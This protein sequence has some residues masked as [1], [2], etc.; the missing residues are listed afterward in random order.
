MKKSTILLAVVL[1]SAAVIGQITKKVCFLG[2]SYTY[3]NNLPALIDSVANHD[4]RDLIK[5]QNTPGGH[6]LDAHSTN[7]TS[8]AKISSNTWDYV[9]LQ[10]QSQLPSFPY[11]QTSVSV[12]PKAEILCDSIRSA[13]ECAVPLFYN[14]WGREIGDSQWDS[15]NTF[16]KM[17]NRLFIAYDYM[18]E[19][20]SGKLSPVGIGFRQVYDDAS[21]IVTNGDLYSSDGS[22]PSM[23]GSYLAACIFYNVIFETTSVGNT[24]LPS[25]VSSGQAA[26][27]QNVANHVVFD[28][29]SVSI[30]YT[31]PI[32]NFL[33]TINGSNVDFSNTSLHAYDYSWDFGDGGSSLL[34][35]PSHAY[36]QYGNYT[37]VLT[38]TYC[39]KQDQYS[40]DIVI[41]DLGDNEI[42]DELFNIYPNP[43]KGT[44]TIQ[45]NNKQSTINIYNLQGQRLKTIVPQSNFVN[46]NLETGIYFI[47]S[48]DTVKKVII[49]K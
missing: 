34:K 44:V 23:F 26:Y 33:S 7:A 16:S 43:S 41:G 49:S 32:A 1:S 38:A 15:I 47:Q 19:S 10:D 8:L 45:S 48:G 27:L 14:T 13:N 24:Y 36:S 28:V 39:G 25:G 20:N 4:G 37:V 11:S 12:Y 3:V 2:N 29:D 21:T 18:A 30:D 5:D 17:N 9:V 31:N 46:I 22:H 42:K 40:F 6:S 35:N